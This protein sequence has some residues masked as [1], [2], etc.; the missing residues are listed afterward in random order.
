MHNGDADDGDRIFFSPPPEQAYR[1]ADY[2]TGPGVSMTRP[3]AGGSSGTALVD[4]LRSTGRG[5]GVGLGLGGR[6][7]GGGE[8][9]ARRHGGYRSDDGGGGGEEHSLREGE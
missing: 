7:E 5:S 6:G 9:G 8:T 1:H 4:M 2:D 3:R